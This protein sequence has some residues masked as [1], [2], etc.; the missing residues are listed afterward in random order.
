MTQG[1]Q[2]SGIIQLFL[3]VLFRVEVRTGILRV[4]KRQKIMHI[5]VVNYYT[6]CLTI[7]PV[8]HIIV[9]GFTMHL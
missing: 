6:H 8:V 7:G 9:L 4:L 1:I 2:I 5:A 3:D